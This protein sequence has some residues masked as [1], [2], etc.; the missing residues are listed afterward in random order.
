MP[1]RMCFHLN[2]AKD[3]MRNL[4]INVRRIQWNFPPNEF[5]WIQWIMTKSKNGM[6][7][8]GI[9]S[10]SYIFCHS[11]RKDTDLT[12]RHSNKKIHFVTLSGNVSLSEYEVSLVTIPF[13]DLGTIHWIQRK[14]FQENSNEIILNGPIKVPNSV[15]SLFWE[16]AVNWQ[17]LPS[18]NKVRLK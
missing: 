13:L 15:S 18:E 7:T 9:S 16:L 2:S 1:H 5:C 6:V 3:E 14:S 11:N 10:N 12:E 17:S 4:K 8:M